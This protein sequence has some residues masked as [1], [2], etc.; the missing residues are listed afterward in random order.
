[1]YVCVCVCVCKRKTKMFQK[2]N[3]FFFKYRIILWTYIIAGSKISNVSWDDIIGDTFSPKHNIKIRR[4]VSDNLF[5]PRKRYIHVYETCTKIWNDKWLLKEEALPFELWTGRLEHL[6]CPTIQ[7]AM[8]ELLKIN[9]RNRTLKSGETMICS[10]SGS[11]LS[12]HP[13]NSLSCHWCSLPIWINVLKQL[14]VIFS[15]SKTVSQIWNPRGPLHRLRLRFL[16][17]LK[18]FCFLISAIWL[19]MKSWLWDFGNPK[20]LQHCV[21]KFACLS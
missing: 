5:W 11:P 20:H 4:V 2:N 9:W 6:Q 10:S 16:S 7:F 1:V 17:P 21:Y 18:I 13:H 15:D 3:F 12:K 8:R 19:R 14:D